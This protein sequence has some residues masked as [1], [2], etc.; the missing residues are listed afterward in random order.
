LASIAVG[1]IIVLLA[2]L[3]DLFKTP[4]APTAI[5]SSFPLWIDVAGLVVTA[6]LMSALTYWSSKL[7]SPPETPVTIAR[8]NRQRMLKRVQTKWITNFLENR[9]YYGYDEELLPLPLRE[10]RGSRIDEVLSDP[11]K[12]T[13]PIS[14]ET[15][16]TQV[17]DQAGGELLILGEPGAGK[18]TL[19]LELARDLLKRAKDDEEGPIP[20]VLMLASWATEKLPLEQWIV[21]ELRMKYDV[22]SQIGEEWMRAKQLLLLL[23]G[24]DEVAPSALPACIN[25]INEYYHQV[26]RSLVV[27]GRTREFLD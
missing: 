23:D 1:A 10:R 8:E 19:L 15:T 5:F 26:H 6:G 22:R 3:L 17:F 2:L 13:R 25:A 27:C 21:K 9:L 11:L 7:I 20:V 14:P 4:I 18:T 16:I 24:L 12:P